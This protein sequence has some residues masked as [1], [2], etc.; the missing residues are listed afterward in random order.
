[1]ENRLFTVVRGTG[2]LITVIVSVIFLVYK[3][4]NFDG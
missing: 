1:M 3:Q 2:D 4:Q